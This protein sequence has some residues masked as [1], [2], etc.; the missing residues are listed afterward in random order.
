MIKKLLVANRGTIAIRIIRACRELGIDTVAIYSTADKDALHV[1]MADESVCI[2]PPAAENSYLSIP[3]VLSAATT[4]GADAVHP[5]YGFLSEN[6]DFAEACQR[7][8]LTFVGPRARHIRLMGDKPRARR[9]MIRAG[10]P[11]L[12]GSDGKGVTELRDAQT[13]AK[14][15]GYP[16]LI[17]AA[18]GGGGKGMRV[19]RDADELARMFPIAQGESEAAFGSKTMYLEKYLERARH[20]EFQIVADNQRNVIHLGERDCSIQRRHQKVI[21]ESPCPVLT[22]RLRQKMGKAAV[23]AASVVGYSNVGTVEFLLAPD[24]EFYFIEMNTRIQ[25]EHGVT[26]MVTGIDLVKESIRLAMGEGLSLKQKQLTFSG[27]AM[28]FRIYAEDPERHIPSP[29]VVSNHHSPGGLGVRVETALYDGYRVPV[30]YDPLVAKVIVH[31]TTRKEVIT[32]AKA[33]LRE[34]MIDGIKTNIPLHIKILHDPDF[35]RGDFATDFMRRY[36]KSAPVPNASE[37]AQV[38]T[39]KAS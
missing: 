3:S 17:K 10:V 16:V 22:D 38:V 11:V 33:A 28:E 4:F 5:G 9:I 12:P 30:H 27:A 34:Y 15:L 6:G 39:S 13:D 25:V 7:S 8:G 23:R 31:A 18:A 32:R 1:R 35:V 26:E 2:G 37:N 36:E 20:V 19:V 14:R 24:N 21:E 29:G